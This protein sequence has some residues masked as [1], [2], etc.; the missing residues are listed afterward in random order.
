MS[1]I[2]PKTTSLITE[3]LTFTPLEVV[4]DIINAAN[5]SV[6]GT[7][8]QL[9]NYLRSSGPSALGY[10][11][12]GSIAETDED[13][14]ELFDDVAMNEIQQ[15][16]HMLEMLM[17]SKVDK[18]YDQF[19][20]INLIKA[21]SINPE[22]DVTPESLAQTRRQLQETTALHRF[23]KA[24]V[25]RNDKVLRSL[26]SLLNPTSTDDSPLAFLL[27]PNSTANDIKSFGE[28]TE[29]AAVQV[30]EL[31]RVVAELKK[32]AIDVFGENGE[33]DAMDL[34]APVSGG[35]R[36]KQWNRALYVEKMSRRHLEKARGLSLT[37][38]GA[39]KS[40][41]D[42]LG[43]KKSELEVSTLEEV[44]EGCPKAQTKHTYVA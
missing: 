12:E 41:G 4:D 15:G 29:F 5:E 38:E 44:L 9:E 27:D 11:A 42:L 30:K 36:E 24:D 20:N 35:L 1:G 26:R 31:H 28:D 37:D 21:T 17:E 2:D 18:A 13:G 33:G 19:E 8:Q 40:G 7:V 34:D 6:Y 10:V 23:L 25:S 32:Q 16:L 14:K 3:H 22:K 43:I 39:L